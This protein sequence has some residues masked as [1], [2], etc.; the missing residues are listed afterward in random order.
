MAALGSLVVKLAL[1]YAEYTKGL[2]KNSQ[3]SLKF[4]KNIQAG[5][6]TAAGSV[7]EFFGGMVK[8]ALKATAAYLSVRTVIDGLSNSIDVLGKLDDMAQKTGSS[9]ENLS[10]IQQVADEFGH[11]LG[12][13]DS[14]ISKLAKGMATF[15]GE[16]NHTARALKA[17][18]VES[19]DAAGNLRDPSQVMIE[20]AKNLQGFQDGAAKSA[21]VT[22]L[23]GKSGAELLPVLNDMADNVDRFTGVSAAAAAQADLFSN[24][25]GAMRT[26]VDD[27]FMSFTTGLLPSLL[28]VTES[29]GDAGEG[30][31][32][33]SD[34]GRRVGSMIEWLLGK[35]SAAQMMFG[36][37]GDLLGTRASQM[38]AFVKGD[39][40]AISQLEKNLENEM[41]K[42]LAE[43][44]NYVA[45]I[46]SGNKEIAESAVEV[47]KQLSYQTGTEGTNEAAKKVDA[48]N[49][50]S[51]KYIETLKIETL[52]VG[53]STIQTKMLAA[54]KQAAITPS[55]A[56][57]VELM[58]Q[59]QA[60]ATLTQFQED[61]KEGFATLQEREDDFWSATNSITDYA[62]ATDDANAA[63]QFEIELMSKSGVERETA[64]AQRKAELELKKQILAI[65]DQVS[66]ADDKAALIEEA[67][68][69]G[70]RAIAAA[71]LQALAK[72]TGEEWARMWGS[73][74]QTGKMAFTQLLGHGVSSFK[75]IGQAIKASIIDMLYQLTV[76]KWII[77]IGASISGSM[78]SGA[79]SAG[80]GGVGGIGG[81][82]SG[83][84]SIFGMGG[85]GAG[86]AGGAASTAFSGIG[87][88]GGAA[89]G[90]GAMSGM[91][92]AA[93]PIAAVAALH[94]AVGSLASSFGAGKKIFGI[95]G[96]SFLT[97]IF[98]IIGVLAGLFGKGPKKYG[99]QLLNG[100]F[101]EDGFAGN[102]QADWTR[103]VGLFGGK[104]RGTTDFAISDEQVATL[105]DTITGITETFKNLI[106]YTG[107][108]D[109]SLTGWSFAVRRA[110]ETEEQQA[111]LTVDLANSIGQKL[112]PEL[113][114]LQ[115]K[116]ESLID[117][118]ARAQAE[119]AL[120]EAAIDLTG[121][122]FGKTGLASLGLRD[123]L[124][125]LLGGL[126]GASA[127]LQ[128]VFDNFYTDAERVASTG[129]LMNAELAR[130]GITTI[131]A[132]REQFRALV[133]AQDLS[134]DAGQ[135][136]FAAL[137]RLAPAFATVTDA[138]GQA[139]IE[140]AIE[141]KRIADSIQLLTTDSFA[142]L[143]DYTKYIRLAANA[144]VT[145]AQPAGPVF[146][147]PAQVFPSF[148]VGTNSLPGDMTINAHA[149]ERIIPAADNRELMRRLSEPNEG[150]SAMAAEIRQLRGELKAAH[151]A[152]ARNTS[153]TAKILD[154]W[155]G[156]GMPETRTMPEQRTA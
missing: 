92:A 68:A 65:T 7:D 115:L 54:A 80:T 29:T 69:I 64:I 124:V 151:L 21:L 60:W 70:E 9:I 135:E 122:S 57:R 61:A 95:K 15:D 89:A 75:A 134:T 71:K 96:D 111:Q 4:A 119:F 14:S 90:M 18:G 130:L 22:D 51:R 117:T 123:S 20:I 45:K 79:A 53:A 153:S 105:D 27:A 5:F 154:R 93:G 47:K 142:T 145:A 74:E 109:R 41:G 50:A 152:I 133:E 42:R 141:A 13:I 59:A 55:Q 1:E 114:A 40:T 73:V 113:T 48:L 85:G 108:A 32:F 100:N 17:L 39:F 102:F 129:R 67:N 126:Q 147:A 35:A 6:D 94:L 87:G 56:L 140:A 66:N 63:A 82:L 150:I 52:G 99:P 143:F 112:I 76:R 34:A 127:T 46:T 23:F 3:E 144:G 139:A 8:E 16:T 19:R 131:P 148:A 31:D 106:K 36:N 97:T 88:A 72:S 121:Q 62:R 104:K 44:Q 107:D 25:I 10:K 91:M 138:I 37:L 12:Q 33:F 11:D 83:L 103:K 26:R 101:T 120:M 116:G 98:P 86:A 118:A 84:G 156:G 28:R 38:M 125:Q 132:T 128:P 81:M 155:E 30:M 149:G 24:Q 146:Q 43:H 2:D 49:D 77:N 110:I 78:A 136:M 58:A 137:I